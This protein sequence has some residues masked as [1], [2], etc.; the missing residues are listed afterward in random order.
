VWN[1]LPRPASDA[2]A[3][4]HQ[5]AGYVW[6]LTSIAPTS[7]KGSGSARATARSATGIVTQTMGELMVTGD[8]GDLMSRPRSARRRTCG[9]SAVGP[10]ASRPCEPVGIRGGCSY[11]DTALAMHFDGSSWATIRRDGSQAAAHR[12]VAG[13]ARTRSGWQEKRCSTSPDG[14]GG[15]ARTPD[16]FRRWASEAL[17]M[18]IAPLPQ[19]LLR[20]PPVSPRR[21]RPPARRAGHPCGPHLEAVCSSDGPVTVKSTTAMEAPVAARK[22]IA[23]DAP[24][25]PRSTAR[26]QG[27]APTLA[28]GSTQSRHRAGRRRRGCSPTGSTP[29]TRGWTWSRTQ[30]TSIDASYFIMEKDPFGLR[31]PRRLAEEAARGSAGAGEHRRDGRHLRQERLQ[32][33]AAGEGLPA[34]GSSTTAPRAYIYHPIYERPLDHRADRLILP[35]RQLGNRNLNNHSETGARVWYLMVCSPSPKR[36]S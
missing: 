36:R 2:P 6:N 34:G 14:A 26:T 16:R 12:R 28:V 4:P 24:P 30:R 9:W 33:A 32:D 31:L 1:G 15:E 8:P 23:L 3:D 19:A 21:R 13:E 25:P 5:R 35:L 17:R 11:P 27:N 7:D 22:P 18:P 20:R 10:T 29:G